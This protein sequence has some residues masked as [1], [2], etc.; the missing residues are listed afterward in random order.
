MGMTSTQLFQWAFVV[1]ILIFLTYAM[2]KIKDEKAS[3]E[4]ESIDVNFF[5]FILKIPMWWTITNDDPEVLIFERT[6][7]RYDW[8]AKFEKLSIKETLE[9]TMV[10]YLDREEIYFDED[11]NEFILE[12]N[13]SHI[14]QDQ[15]LISQIDEF[16][17]IEGRGTEKVTD[18]VYIDFIWIKLKND[19]HCYL[20]QSHSSVLNGSVEGPFFEETIKRLAIK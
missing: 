13:P 18:R 19:D 3:F 9:K 12:Q 15:K 17:K 5:N 11:E 20:M 8:F 10:A 14:L 7:T 4:E 2:F 1:G 6:D 16:L